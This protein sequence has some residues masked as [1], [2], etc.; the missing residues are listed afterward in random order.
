MGG[1]SGRSDLY[2]S[3]ANSE[4]RT[5]LSPSNRLLLPKPQVWPSLVTASDRTKQQTHPGYHAPAGVARVRDSA[6][7]APPFPTRGNAA[8]FLE[9][10]T[11]AA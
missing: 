1:G 3:H 7:L 8:R 11:A 9:L 6:L 10:S 5:P 2:P 4:H